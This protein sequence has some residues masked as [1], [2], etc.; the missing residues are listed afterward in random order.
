M[1]DLDLDMLNQLV[2][3]LTRE[4]LVTEMLPA[5]VAELRAGRELRRSIDA[6]GARMMMGSPA[7]AILFA[8]AIADARDAYDAAIKEGT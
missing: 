1:S 4:Q 2:P 3:T 5:L 8:S 6:A 7:G